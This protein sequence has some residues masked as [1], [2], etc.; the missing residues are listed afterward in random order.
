MTTMT[1]SL[2]TDGHAVEGDP[3]F[4]DR[5]GNKCF[6]PQQTQAGPGVAQYIGEPLDKAHTMMGI[7]TLRMEFTT[8]ATD[9]WI[10]ARLFDLP[11]TG[12]PTMVARGVC[13]VN[14]TAHPDVGCETFDML[15]NGWR[16]EAEHRV[17][18]ELSQSDT[19]FLRKSNQA[20]SI[21]FTE[22]EIDIPTVAETR[23]RDFRD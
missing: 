4:R 23:R 15:G 5:Q 7:P 2:A 3:V 10:S 1:S 8:S 16:F 9:Y 20:S 12:R 11:P 14:K 17:M 6:T 21:Q 13:K 19:P 22:V 18:L